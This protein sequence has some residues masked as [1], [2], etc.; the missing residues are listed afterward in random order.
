MVDRVGIYVFEAVRLALSS[1]LL[2]LQIGHGQRLTQQTARTLHLG[3]RE[4]S[5]LSD[6][7]AFLSTLFFRSEH[8]KAR[9]KVTGFISV[10]RASLGSF[11]YFGWDAGFHELC[12]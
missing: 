8:L 1:H 12:L 5:V 11:L 10:M 3:R 4:C 9:C 2:R 7:A 6:T